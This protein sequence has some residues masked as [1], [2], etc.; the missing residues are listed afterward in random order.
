MA[1]NQYLRHFVE[2][3]FTHIID[4]LRTRLACVDYVDWHH[5]VLVEEGS[6]HS[7]TQAKHIGAKELQEF[8]Q[9]LVEIDW[10]VHIQPAIEAC[11]VETLSHMFTEVEG[12]MSQEEDLRVEQIHERINQYKV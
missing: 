10:V 3:E 9:A 7:G 4:F 12:Q 2:E 8:D 6:Q 1:Y 5:E 11:V